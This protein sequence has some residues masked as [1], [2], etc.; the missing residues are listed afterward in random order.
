[1]VRR[2][3]IALFAIILLSTATVVESKWWWFWKRNKESDLQR[4]V[5][6]AVK[7]QNVAVLFTQE[8][9]VATPAT[10]AGTEG[11]AGQLSAEEQQKQEENEETLEKVLRALR[12]Y[13][14]W[15]RWR[16]WCDIYYFKVDL[17]AGETVPQK[18]LKDGCSSFPCGA[19]L[20]RT[21]DGY[22]TK[23]TLN[24]EVVLQEE[25]KD[26]T[27][28]IRTTTIDVCSKKD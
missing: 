1:M 21:E 11:A 3:N 14:R 7:Y 6:K 22:E 20:V 4:F 28:K 18:F 8:N 9:E 10:G 26:L 2:N 16:K 27:K 25:Y 13:T 19:L 12:A 15:Y 17:E 24:K 23:F 5:K